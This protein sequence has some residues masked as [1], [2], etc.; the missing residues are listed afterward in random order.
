MSK[1]VKLAFLASFTLTLALSFLFFELRSLY[2]NNSKTS[3]NLENY[4]NPL[5][6]KQISQNTNLDNNSEEI[7]SVSLNLPKLG[8]NFPLE[9]ATKA[10]NNLGAVPVNA[11][12][13]I[14]FREN[15]QSDSNHTMV[16]GGYTQTPS[17]NAAAFIKLLKLQPEDLV[18]IS[19]NGGKTLSYTIYQ[20]ELT[21]LD[22][23]P[24]DNKFEADTNKKL[25][26]FTLDPLWNAK[27]KSFS[28][29]II[30]YA[31]LKDD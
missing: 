10:A 12:N 7:G 17:G 11:D 21:S 23:N 28:N 31:N 15:P 22:K 20:R 16:V 9:T 1:K 6:I 2:F 29:R 27:K 24:F 3:L 13:L 26:L 8:L 30:L 19:F 5:V 18:E 14:W 4:K 25:I